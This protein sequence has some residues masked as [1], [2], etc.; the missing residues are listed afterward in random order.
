MANYAV[1]P[2]LLLPF[3]PD[4]TELDTWKGTCYVS[5]VG[6]MFLQT[7]LMGVKIP[8]HTNFE[9]V[10]LRFYVRY[11]HQGVWRR[12]VVFIKELVPKFA[13]TWVANTLYGEHYQ[14]LRMSHNW[15][16]TAE[17][18]DVRYSWET[19]NPH[20]IEI[21]ASAHAVPLEEGSEAEFITEHYWG[22]TRLGPDKTAY[23]QVAHPRWDVY[24]V[25]SYRIEVDFEQVYGKQFVFLN[26]QNPL[27]VFLAEGSQ[28]QIGSKYMC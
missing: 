2:A 17:H 8:F 6:F 1:D 7:R 4:K 27:S 11:K 28:I 10:N 25:Q 22:Y 21:S 19:T 9:E 24:P 23:Y 18:L 16:Q 15:E 26:S 13:I 14:T 5:L 3:L 20:S 12:G